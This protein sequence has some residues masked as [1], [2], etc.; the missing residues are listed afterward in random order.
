MFKM[1][2][3]NWLTMGSDAELV[4]LSMGLAIRDMHAVHF[5]EGDKFLEDYP[6]WVQSSPFTVSN[7]NRL[8]DIWGKQLPADKD[9]SDGVEEEVDPKGKG[10]AKASGCK[11]RKVDPPKN[12]SDEEET[13]P[14]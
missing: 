13:N 11:K 14:V 2:C 9:V 6:N 5:V 4:V 3:E 10:K 12:D 1:A 7:V 8:M